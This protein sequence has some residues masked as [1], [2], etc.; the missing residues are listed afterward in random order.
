MVKSL[1][2]SYKAGKVI[3]ACDKGASSYRRNILPEYKQNRQ[4]TRDKQTEQ[5]RLEFEAFFQEFNLA[6]DILKNSGDY[7][8]LQFPGVEADDIAAYIVRKYKKTHTIWLM[9]SDKD[10]DLLIDKNVSSTGCVFFMLF[11]IELAK[12]ALRQPRQ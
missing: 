1:Q 10:W 12:S 4:E 6:L 8:V 3:I 5:E 7:P 9:S 2:K 11:K